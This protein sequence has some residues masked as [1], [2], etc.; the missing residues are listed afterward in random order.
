LSV[1]GESFPEQEQKNMI[2]ANKN[3]RY[4]TVLLI[5]LA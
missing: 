5:C 4:I 2:T 1:A 3:N